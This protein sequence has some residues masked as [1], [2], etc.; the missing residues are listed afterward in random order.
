MRL[1]QHPIL[2]NYY[3]TYRCNAKCGF[4]DIWERPSPY[5]TIE[6]V[7]TNLISLKKLGI[8]VIDFTGGEPLLHRDIDHFFA[9][10][11]KLGFI[12]TLTTNG[13]LYPKHAEGLKGKVDM[14]HF[15]L[16]TAHKEKHDTMRG[17]A[18]YDHVME[19][20][21]IAKSLGERPDILMTVFEDNIGEI[22]KLYT[23]VCLPN[24]LILILNPSFEYNEVETGSE[25]SNQSLETLT[26]WGKKKNIYLNQAFIQL[27]RDGG[28]QTEK[29]VCKAASTTLVISPENELLL[30]C[31]HLGTKGF[32]IDGDLEKVYHS[33]EAQKLIKLEGRLPECQGCTINCYMQPS[34]AVEMNKYFWLALPSTFKYNW[35]KGTWRQLV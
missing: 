27:R 21:Q 6:Q 14:L 16:D 30:P 26:R 10:A 19:S 1:I 13:L 9:F 31:Y 33:T 34:F 3:V 23:D 28:N 8:K 35:I 32:A 29:P 17:V 15:S 2:C 22:E 12:T 7:E 5:V 11:K 20:I 18:C 25:L 24:D 4:C